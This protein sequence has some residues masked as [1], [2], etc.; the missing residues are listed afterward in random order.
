[1]DFVHKSGLSVN[2]GTCRARRRLS[3]ALQSL[4]QDDLLNLPSLQG[5]EIL[6]RYLV[7]IEMAVARNPRCP[8][9]QDL[10]AVV[11]STVNE[12]GGLV[13]PEYSASSPRSRRTR[14]SR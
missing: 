11:A 10:D 2:S 8:D 4:M 1:M 12:Y 5:V 9:F 7:Q 3:E 14:P 13:L 6:T